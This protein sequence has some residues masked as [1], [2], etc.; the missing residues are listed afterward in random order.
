MAPIPQGFRGLRGCRQFTERGDTRASEEHFACNDTC[1]AVHGACERCVTAGLH[2]CIA[3]LRS[4]VSLSV[5]AVVFRV[6]F[7]VQYTI[8]SSLPAQLFIH[9]HH[10][11]H[12]QPG[13]TRTGR[14]MWELTVAVVDPFLPGLIPHVP[15]HDR[16]TAAE[17]EG[18]V[19]IV[20]GGGTG[21]ESLEEGGEEKEKET[22]PP[23]T[24][25]DAVVVAA[26]VVV[27]VEDQAGAS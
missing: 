16:D 26:D 2:I 24:D 27:D 8:L 4:V 22:I 19:P 13:D 15:F 23:V 7:P 21:G 25:H 6:L 5:C 11:T 17:T 10:P 18:D 3:A 12:L 20:E 9:T 14:E 1:W